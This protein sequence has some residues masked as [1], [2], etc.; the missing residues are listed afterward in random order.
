MI[1]DVS[2]YVSVRDRA[3]QLGCMVSDRISV[4]PANFESAVSINDFLQR[5]EAATLRTLFRLNGVPSDDLVSR[6]Q[7]GAY[8]QNNSIEWIAPTLFVAGSIW[9]QEP[10]VVNLAL[11]VLSTYIT[12]FFKGAPGRKTV[13][14]EIV[15]E[16]RRSTLCKRLKYEGD[17]EGIRELAA[18]IGRLADE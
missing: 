16:K 18:A 6:E 2:N 10:N 14:L 7:R 5:T 9:S 17:A 1:T 15:V 4:L 12:D 3:E 8:I 11:N 13:K